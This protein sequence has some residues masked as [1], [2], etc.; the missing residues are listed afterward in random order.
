[1]ANNPLEVG[2]MVS[3]VPRTKNG[4]VLKHFSR[5]YKEMN[6]LA[7]DLLVGY[8]TEEYTSTSGENVIII[9]WHNEKAAPTH[10]AKAVSNEY[11]TKL[12]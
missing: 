12:S 10:Y 8:V 11:L 9:K 7:T 1:L 3:L 2:D 6:N 5:A 4:N